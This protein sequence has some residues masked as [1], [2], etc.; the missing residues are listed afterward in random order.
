M[1]GRDGM[2]PRGRGL[3]TG[4]KMGWCG[5]ANAPLD[6]LSRGPRLGIGWGAGR[7]GGWRHRYC[8]RATRLSG[9]RSVWMGWPGVGASSPPAVSQEQKQAALAEEVKTIEQVL[10]NMKAKLRELENPKATTVST[11][12]RDAERK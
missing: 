10:G 2:G 3:A 1:P 7:G 5:G 12:D 9:W 11:R 6:T 8:Y 4:R